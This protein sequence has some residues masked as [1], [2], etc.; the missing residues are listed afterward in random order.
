[1]LFDPILH[2]QLNTFVISL[3]DTY[4]MKQ[5]YMH[6][7]TQLCFPGFFT[8]FLCSVA[9]T[10]GHNGVFPVLYI[11]FDAVLHAP[12]GTLAFSVF[13]YILFDPVLTRFNK[14]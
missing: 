4:C 1:M 10:V 7:C 12:L 9:W 13:L 14:I 2:A 6:R 5:C 11:I 3:F 8:Y